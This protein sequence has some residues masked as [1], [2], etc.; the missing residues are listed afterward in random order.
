MPGAQAR[1]GH[2]RDAPPPPPQDRLSAQIV[3]AQFQ[4]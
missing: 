4:A 2:G 3:R 1:S